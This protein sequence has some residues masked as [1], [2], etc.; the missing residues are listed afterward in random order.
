MYRWPEIFFPTPKKQNAQK[1][2]DDIARIY[3]IYMHMCELAVHVLS[4]FH[5]PVTGTPS[6]TLHP[7]FP[8]GWMAGVMIAWVDGL[9]EALANSFLK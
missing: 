3:R 5:T 1:L 4:L 8:R 9:R 2:P 6:R 7:I